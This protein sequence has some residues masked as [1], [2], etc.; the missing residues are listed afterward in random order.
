MKGPSFN[1]GRTPN[2][3]QNPSD[4]S[5][6]FSVTRRKYKSKRVGSIGGFMKRVLNSC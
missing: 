1:L 4:I 2:F 3:H 6:L 5:R